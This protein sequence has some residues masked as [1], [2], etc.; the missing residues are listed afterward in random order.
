M[1]TIKQNVEQ[2]LTE[3]PETRD[4]NVE[5]CCN[6][7]RFINNIDIFKL[8]AMG[9]FIMIRSKKIPDMSTITRYSRQLQEKNIN[10]RGKE[11]EKRKKLVPKVQKDLGYNVKV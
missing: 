1:K 9:L 6:Y 5:L 2:I 11:W 4:S 10:L 8:S 3:N 7:Y